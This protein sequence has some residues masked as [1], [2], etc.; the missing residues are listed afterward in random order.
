MKRNKN[1]ETLSWEHH[2]GLVLAFRLERGLKTNV[3]IKLVTDY[4]LF[5][6]DQILKHHF[7][8][9]EQTLQQPLQRSQDG[10]LL[11]KQMMNEH[12]QFNDLVK[13]IRQNKRNSFVVVIL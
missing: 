8:Q 3:D 12:R 1:L 7:W 11:L 4:L 6:W 2:E 9:E 13:I 5:V 10:Q